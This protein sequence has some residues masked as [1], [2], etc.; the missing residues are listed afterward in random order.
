MLFAL[1]A[2]AGE[3]KY[4]ELVLS[5]VKDGTAKQVFAPTTP[6]IFLSTK[7]VD[8]PTGA[9]LNAAWI[10]EKTKVAPANYQIDSTELNVGSLMNRA[11]FSMTKPNAGW[12]PGEYRVDLAING[13]LLNT[14]RFK[15][16]P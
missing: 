3:P 15:V 11:T 5:D 10:A 4:G 13:K 8:V 1:A 6:K 2:I 7:L 14:V 9:K 12:P 16:A